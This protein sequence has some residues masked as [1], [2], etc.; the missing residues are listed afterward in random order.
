M[1]KKSQKITYRAKRNI[2]KS[3]DEERY[4]KYLVE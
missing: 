4:M 2:A 3:E 1:I